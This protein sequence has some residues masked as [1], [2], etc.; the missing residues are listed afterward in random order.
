MA[1]TALTQNQDVSK[2]ECISESSLPVQNDF[3]TSFLEQ[4][5]LT[6]SHRPYPSSRYTDR[7]QVASRP[8]SCRRVYTKSDT[9][10]VYGGT[11][12]LNSCPLPPPRILFHSITRTPYLRVTLDMQCIPQAALVFSAPNSTRRGQEPGTRSN[13]L[14]EARGDGVPEKK[15]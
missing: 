3:R 2:N 6:K 14:R 4:Y 13:V 11:P 15:I 1:A 9:Y 10:S 8:P 12:A 5:L 7:R